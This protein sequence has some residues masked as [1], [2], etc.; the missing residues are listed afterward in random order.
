[1][2]GILA[3]GAQ[4]IGGVQVGTAG[5]GIYSGYRLAGGDDF[6]SLSHVQQHDPS[7]SY[8]PSH[9]RRGRRAINGASNDYYW[10][11]DHTG[12]ADDNRGVPCGVTDILAQS[13]S[14]VLL[15][16]RLA[17]AAEKLLDWGTSASTGPDR[18]QAAASLHSAGYQG[19]KWPCI[20]EARVKLPTPAQGAAGMWSAFWLED[21]L[22]A[23]P[24]TGEWDFEWI[25]NGNLFT[26]FITSSG[27]A[28]SNDA[29]IATTVVAT[30]TD[31]AFHTVTLKATASTLQFY[32]DGTL[33][34]TASKR[35]DASVTG[36]MFWWLRHGVDLTPGIFGM[37]YSSAAWA[38]KNP[39][40]EVDWVRIW[41]QPTASD[42]GYKGIVQT[43]N[44]GFTGSF[45]VTLPSMT[46]L[47][48]GTGFTE[49]LVAQPFEDMA[50]GMTSVPTS[51]NIDTW[52]GTTPSANYAG[53]SIF[54][55]NKTTRAF[56]GGSFD[57]A[58]RAF[59]HLIAWDDTNG[60]LAGVARVVVNVGPRVTLGTQAW[61][62]GT[63]VSVDVYAAC[64]A[65]MLVTDGTAKAKTISV[66]GLPTGLSYSDSTGLITGTPTVDGSGNL[67][68]TVTNSLGQSATSSVAYSVSA[69]TG[70]VAAPTLTGSPTLLRSWDFGNTATI[71]QS[72][73]SID[74]IAATDG[75]TG[76]LSSTGT[77]R[78]TVTTQGGKQVAQFSAASSQR[79]TANNASG[80]NSAN[81]ITM[82]AIFEPTSTASSVGIAE[83]SAGF[84]AFSNSRNTLLASATTGYQFRKYSDVLND[85]SQASPGGGYT[86]GIHLLIGRCP[87]GTSAAKFNADGQGTAITAGT[88][89]ANSTTI[90]WTTLGCTRESSAFAKFANGY[91]YRV[92]FYS[93]SLTDT[94]CEEIAT[95]AAAN[96]G[97]ANSA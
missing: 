27:G 88:S 5:T 51:T 45:N 81:G 15:K 10:T 29:T 96:Y 1:V 9:R 60:G 41:T 48:G 37:T 89:V 80:Y 42:L 6:G 79:L 77:N 32:V 35:P 52:Y 59:L 23:W 8:F 58:G 13:G 40:M 39:I 73:G 24:A 2:R 55:W 26:N 14:S 87:S 17:T 78:P 72:G 70:G 56:T 21:M 53:P 20:V 36:P 54:T 34:S 91:L 67:S 25:D 93:G 30:H 82:V 64:D 47:W 74:S 16:T 28:A 4:T 43:V 71:T 76:A 11:P 95:W 7:G 90:A 69:G 19:V 62:N 49:Y 12:Y 86:S 75:T 94:Q 97:T 31:A 33:V 83:I 18:P 66:T 44:V 85:L 63:P 22:P 61:T 3:G 84:D 65:G 38:G 50:P 46:A 57:R 68:V 92:L